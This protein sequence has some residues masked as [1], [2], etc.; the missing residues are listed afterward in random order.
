MSKP[1]V[2]TA[3]HRL[4][5]HFSGR[6]QGVGF[7]YTA[8]NIAIRHN[9]TGYVRNLPDG[10]VELVMEGPDEE[11]HSVVEAVKE[12]MSDYIRQANE[13]E[14]PSTGEFPHFSIRHC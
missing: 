10:R 8:R 2:E 13:I 4:H 11:L 7:R 5:C 12:K 14:F 9:V 6:V 1:M 3:V